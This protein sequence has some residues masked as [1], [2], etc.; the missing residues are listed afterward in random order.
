MKFTNTALVVAAIV[1]PIAAFQSAMKAP[2]VF[3][4][5]HNG[6][7]LQAVSSMK[8]QSFGP[9]TVFKADDDNNDSQSEE[10]KSG[11]QRLF[12][13]AEKAK[14][15]GRG[16]PIYTPGPYTNQ[17]LSALAYVIPI[18]DAS[19]LSKYMFEAYP[20]I[21][22]AYNTLFGP[23]AAIYNGV[24]FLPFAVFFLMSY[25][26]RAPNFPVEIR[27]HFAQAFMIGLV[28]FVPSLLFG[29]LEKAG[30][31]GVAVGYNTAFVWVMIS[32]L[33]MQ[34]IL[35]NP[36]SV[37]KNPMHVNVVGWAMRYMNYTP[38]MVPPQPPRK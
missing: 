20:D 27:F 9:E 21:G 14:K 11:L 7:K 29:L 24:P 16:P 1:G 6:L 17:L 34:A 10:T 35:I 37:S 5:Y 13:E 12:D 15:E 31:P 32:C 36:I 30:V 19:D 33:A 25:V 26:C 3:T 28:Q 23:I 8:S 18:A 22:T 38:D 2:A 4:R